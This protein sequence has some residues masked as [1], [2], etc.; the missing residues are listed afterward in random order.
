MK[1]ANKPISWYQLL[2]RIGKQTVYK[3][4]NTRVQVM[5]DGE[6][7]D[8]K[9]VFTDSG[10]NF[11]LELIDDRRRWIP[12]TEKDHPTHCEPCEVTVKDAYG[13][14]REIGYFADRWRREADESSLDVIAWKEISKPYDIRISDKYISKSLCMDEFH[15]AFPVLKKEDIVMC[16]RKEP[17]FKEIIQDNNSLFEKYK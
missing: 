6:L 16:S 8:C 13:T 17:I 7:K 14:R 5:V 10:N 1:K 15:S 12:C 11:H 2:R 9:L 3:T 4:R